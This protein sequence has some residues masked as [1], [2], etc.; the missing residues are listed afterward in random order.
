MKKVLVTVAALGLVFG[1][2]A[3]ALALDKPSRAAE[4][5]EPDTLRRVPAPTAP[6]VA[7]WSV[8]GQWVLAGA[9]LSNGYGAPGGAAVNPVND[10]P[11][12]GPSDSNDAFY[13]YSFKIL[14]VLQ[15]NDKIA[16]K[17]ELRF[18]DRAVLGATD[19]SGD[20]RQDNR[21][22]LY[23][24]Y[25]EWDSPYGKTRFG[26]TPAGAWGT[27]KFLDSTRQGQRLMWWPN[28]MPENWSALLFTEKLA[29]RDAGVPP[30]DGPNVSDAD[31]DAYYVGLS[32]KAD[33]GSTNSALWFVRNATSDEGVDTLSP[34]TSANLWLNG[35]YNFDAITFEWE[36][37]WGFG[38]ASSTVYQNTLA[39]MG[40]VAWKTGDFT[41]GGL[42]IYCSGD[43]TPSDDDKETACGND[44][45]TGRDF[46]PYQIMMGDYMNLWNGDNPLS[47]N[48]I[49][50]SLQ[51]SSSANTGLWSIGAYG[52][53]AMSPKMSL[54]GEVGY[55]AATDELTGYDDDYGLE[56]GIGMGYKLM[57]NLSY[58]AHFSYL[59]TGDF[60]KEGSS[61]LETED[62]Y[63][64]AHALSMKF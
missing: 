39:F 47:G 52:K 57:D 53:F 20:S 18:V 34:Y 7:L 41:L 19:I 9:Y 35:K 21:M 51:T 17:G 2:A 40:D 12:V 46:N 24:V 1:V 59:M 29:E 23:T 60:F 62:I 22:K 13:I 38:E 31:T 8:S 32:Y 16:V 14:P 44:R 4:S 37:D 58:N 10:P 36:L 63:L 30:G 33:F 5:E 49:H 64:I 43:D 11:F 55:F 6:G 54:S 61:N 26:R 28:M 56:L 27:S 50:P 15:V 42:F 3:N 25:M 45:G 48:S